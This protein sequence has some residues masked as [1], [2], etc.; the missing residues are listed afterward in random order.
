MIVA[1]K[2]ATVISRREEKQDTLRKLRRLG[3]L[4]LNAIPAQ[5]LPAQAWREKKVLLEK[6]LA[7]IADP[8]RRTEGP[9]AGTDAVGGLETALVTARS[10]LDKDEAIR[11]LTEMSG[12]LDREVL[13]LAEWEGVSLTDL[14]AIREQGYEITFFEVPPKKLG[15]IPS[16]FKPFIVKRGKTL[17]WVALFL[18]T[19]TVLDLEFNP[20]EPPRRSSAE[21]DK[22]LAENRSDQQRR[23]QELDKL[24]V[25]AGE[26]ERAILAAG[27]EIELAEA[28][29]AMGQSEDLS[30]LSGFLPDDRVASLKEACRDNGWAL[31]IQEPA[32]ADEV[33]T[34]VRNKRWIEI[35]NPVFQLLGTVPGYH[36]F[37]ISLIFLLFFTFFFAAIIGDAGYGLVI[38]SPSLF[39]GVRTRRQGKKIPAALL[40]MMILSSATILWGALTG[41]WFGSEKLAALP[42]LSWM[43]VPPLSSFNPA[44]GETFKFIFFVV[45]TVQ[46]SIA[47]LWSFFRQSRQKPF[48][49][50]LAQLGWLSL[51]LGLYYLVL[52]LVISTVKYP[53]PIHGKWL[54]G[55]GLLLIIV[56]SRQ[57]GR[58]FHGVAMSMANLL[59]TL[60]SSISAFADIISYIRLFAV[61]LAGIEI[62]KSFN[63]MAAGFGTHIGGLIAAGLILLLGHALNLSMGA[64]SVVVHGV[65]LNML[66]FSGHLGMEWSGRPYKPFKE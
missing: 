11:V 50:S 58:F 21:L 27:R 37:D 6:A 10:I 15:M 44:S 33:P 51:V 12:N 24:A 56:F 20:L 8:A 14:R 53:V 7:V 25:K 39:F 13:R 65:R 17:L 34:I 1:M 42:F 47:H 62:A 31:M 45:G 3:V 5:V 18:K 60:L 52:N 22:L 9:C 29:A 41:N 63:A 36:E 2:K 59:T 61:G 66:E 49:R 19:G 26:I 32:G 54:I 40:L 46:I 57:E 43:I 35:I 55:G 23:R 30:Y 4:H 64:L 38:F 48:I 16:A 28:T